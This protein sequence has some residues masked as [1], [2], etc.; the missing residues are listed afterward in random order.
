MYRLTALSL[1]QRAVVV[2]LTLLIA[3]GGAFG[4]TQL[5]S[6]LLP[7]FEIPI[8]TVITVQPGAGPETV[9]S[10]ISQPITNAL[11]GIQGMKSVQ[12]QSSEGFSVVVAEFDYGQDMAKAQQDIS[13]AITNVTL[14]SGVAQ[15][16]IQRINLQQFPVIQLAITSEDG[17]DL[18][19]LRAVADTQFVPKLS[20]ADG[21]SRVE[22]VGGSTNQLVIALDPQKMATNGITT[23]QVSGALQANNISIPAGTIADGTTTLPVRVGSQITTTDA[24]KALVVGVTPGANPKPVTLGE[25][26]KVDVVA[27]DT[28][29]VARTNG[30][31]SIAINV[32]MSQGANTVD[33][34]AAVRDQLKQVE[35]DLDASGTKVNVTTLLD[36]S[37][38][39]QSSIDSLVREALL[40]AVFAI[41]VILVF[42]LSVRSTLVT[43][44]SI[45]TSMLITF[46]ILWWQ[47]ISLNIMTLGGLAVAVGRVVDD[48]IVVLEAIFRHVKRGE[49][50]K[51]ATIN[52]TKEVALAITASTLTTV[53]VFLPL[54]VVGGLIGEI[55]R[56]FALTVT[57][58]LL[59]SLLV[60][61]TI[62]PVM[63]SFFI[64]AN[65]EGAE[66]EATDH[67]PRIARYYEPILRKA[68]LHP[69]I[70]LVL[71][72]VIFI[73]SLGLT[74]LIGTS[75]LP[76]SGEK[77]ASI[78]ID[79]P[80]GTSQQATVDQVAAMEQAVKDTANVESLQ[81]QIGGDDLTAAL[82]GASG[83]RATMTVVFDN[84]V[85]LTQTLNDVRSA[86]EAKANG[87]KVSV[88]NLDSQGGAN[89]QVVIS[90]TDYAAVSQAANDLT[91]KLQGVNDLANVENDVVAA[92]PE[93]QVTIDPAKAAAAGTTTAQV[94]MLVRNALTGSSAG[95]ITLENGTFPVQLIVSGADSK[96]TL[97]KLPVAGGGTVTLDQIAT[98]EQVDGPVQVS[99]IDGARS[100]TISGTITTE[101]TGAV[102]QDVAKIVADYN[103]PEGVKVSIG[104]IGQDQGSAFASMGIAML[105][106]I[107]A[108]Y[109]IMVA[110]FGSLTTPFVILFSLPLAVIGVI[111]ALLLTGKTLGLPALIGVLM[112]IGIVVT[113][114]IVLLEYVI[115]LRH[116][117]G[118]ELRDALIEGG[119]TRLRPILMTAVATILALIPLALSQEGGA[120]IASDLAVVVI[121]GL[122]TSTLL[123][124]IVVP[125]IYELIGGWQDRRQAKKDRKEAEAAERRARERAE[126]E[127]AKAAAAAGNAS[128]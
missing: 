105:V 128:A 93:L 119:K 10:T 125:V 65:P 78:V 74:P 86:L 62:V 101:A 104:G 33:T 15:P 35:S 64:K 99:R 31:P 1:K 44:I 94:G 43:A 97:A 118:L 114:A 70:T 111:L 90:G 117:R 63:A 96:E 61:L 6:E 76:S 66:I 11:T 81:T 60:A 7:N 73:A 37:Q 42:L 57:F 69:V 46:I 120:I 54:A 122:L 85:D 84:S 5:R 95:V 4:V 26:A 58:A 22:V 23:D 49:P 20:S 108:V 50:V 8:I 113:N 123:T 88:S 102:N 68:L 89:I 30:S 75:F 24:L 106:A 107:A 100:A 127:A 103:A 115:E 48:S 87:A 13:E 80:E 109:I 126:R 51:Q 77:G 47:G 112:L 92:K 67:H 18:S 21:V 17:K 55:F 12:T 79:Y 116:N 56:P 124:L 16:K 2:L 98:I 9:D 29:G 3:L 39:I 53:A 25:I 45:P 19:T 36:Q 34:A 71:V 27:A 110:S 41:I 40:G 82:S 83:S 121:G 14:P 59:S 28:S 91:A 72:A 38:Y 32:Y 52:G